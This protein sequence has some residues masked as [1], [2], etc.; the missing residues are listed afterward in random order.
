MLSPAAFVDGVAAET[1][2]NVWVKISSHQDNV[3]QDITWLQLSRSVDCM[4]RWI[5]KELGLGEG[6]EPVAYAGVND[7]R[8][9]IIILAALKTGY[10]VRPVTHFKSQACLLMPL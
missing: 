10:K 5:E 4:A 2:N 1:P 8:C 6:G 7:I 9:P 3:W